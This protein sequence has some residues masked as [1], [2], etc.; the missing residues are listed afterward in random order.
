MVSR[1]LA[2]RLGL[3]A[4]AA[5]LAAVAIDTGARTTHQGGSH[6]EAG[7]R[8]RARR[9]GATGEASSPASSA[10]GGASGVGART[11]LGTAP[12]GSTPPPGTELHATAPSTTPERAPS[13]LSPASPGTSPAP[14]EAVAPGAGPAPSSALRFFGPPEDHA[15]YL[16][17]DDGWYPNTK[18]LDLMRADHVPLTTF[19]I[20]RAADDDPE[21][22]AYW[23]AFVDAGGV[24]QNHTVSHPWLTKVPA[25]DV[26][27]QWAG[28]SAAFT[29]WFGFRPTLGRPPYGAVNDAVWQA[30]ANCGLEELV[31]WS[32][33]DNGHG[34]QTWNQ[35]SLQPG[36]IVLMHWDPGLYGEL[37]QVL[38]TFAGLG[39]SRPTSDARVT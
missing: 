16:T 10:P 37:R 36:A 31:M 15:V 8:G 18:V 27:G 6:L 19:L 20:S 11:A 17:V 34:L 26:E 22:L 12:R 4:A 38:S 2:L 24:V 5:A 30:A 1:R 33:V 13:S 25:G 7:V 23:K 35:Q 3:G 29:N 14:P 39:V 28:A 21:H 9:R 32:A